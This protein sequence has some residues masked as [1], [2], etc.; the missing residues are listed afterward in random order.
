MR[1]LRLLSFSGPLFVLASAGVMVL[2]AHCGGGDTESNPPPDN[3]T[4]G[5]AETEG[6]AVGESGTEVGDSVAPDTTPDTPLPTIT[7]S[8]Q[9]VFHAP[10]RVNHNPDSLRRVANAGMV[11]LDDGRLM[12]AMLEAVDTGTRYGLWARTVDPVTSKAA[13]DE[14]LDVD[15]DNLVAGSGFRVFAIQGG[16]VGVSYG[17][18]HVKVWSKGKWSPDLAATMTA[19]GGLTYLAAPSGQVLVT[20]TSGAAPFAQ[21][22]VYRPDEGGVK[23][24]WSTPQTLDLE[25]MTGGA[26]IDPQLL[27]DG[28]FLTLIWQGAGGPAIRTRSLSGAWSASTP[29]AE[30]GATDAS[31]SYRLLDDG[32]IVLVAL[33]GTGD[34]RRVVTSTW[35]A[36]DNWTTARLLSKPT[37][38]SNGVI[39]SPSG[40]FLFSV[41]GSEVEFVAWVAGCATAAKDCEFHAVSRRYAGGVWK[42]PVDLGI[43]ES[44][45]KGAEGTSVSGLDGS[46]PLI[47]RTNT[48]R[49]QIEFRVRNDATTFK[50]SVTLGKDSPYFSDS[51]T[52]QAAFFGGWQGLWT[53]TTRTTTATPAVSLPTAVGKIDPTADKVTWGLITAGSFELRGFGDSYPYALGSGGFTVGV[54]NATDGSSTSPIIAYIGAAGGSPEAGPAMSSDE[55]SAFFANFPRTQPR[56]NRDRSAIFV[57]NATLNDSTAPGSRLRAYA[58]NGV[59]G[60]VPKILANESRAPR[61][62][63]TSSDPTTGAGALSYGC[64]GA[65][66]YAVDPVDGSHALEL[67]L[68]DEV[69]SSG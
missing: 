68:V 67:V 29:K 18:G 60:T 63:P 25:G 62:F 9:P 36:T 2:T 19:S 49:T 1:T 35:N 40:P 32:S 20:R 14:R 5:A 41:S 7:C 31:P 51:T 26:R 24:S 47:A 58:F 6:D 34:T 64:G 52:I 13:D 21:A 42:D 16:A 4:G 33:E 12:V 56:M 48:A 10:V 44:G 11:Q 43:G 27:P 8:K 30:I 59:G 61:Y 23:G 39:P 17:G 66:L 3:D 45:R 55:K 28:R 38:D 37:A 50:P 46:T 53:A 69:P 57:V 15:A 54:N 65:I 22:A